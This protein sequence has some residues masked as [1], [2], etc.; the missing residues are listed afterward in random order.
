LLSTKGTRKAVLGFYSEAARE[1]GILIVVFA[2]LDVLLVG[3]TE[4]TFWN[5]AAWCCSGLLL[6]MFGV[7]LDPEIR[8]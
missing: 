5:L 7:H 6:L 3:D 8:R 1:A 2:S 4:A